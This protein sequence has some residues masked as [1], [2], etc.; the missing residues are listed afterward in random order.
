MFSFNNPFGACEK[1]DGLGVIQYFDENK[2]ISD[3]EAS[4]NSGAI[5]GWNKRNRFYYHQLKCLAAHYKFDLNCSWGSLGK[6]IQKIILYGS[7]DRIDFSKRFKAL[8]TGRPIKIFYFFINF[9][10][11]VHPY[12]PSLPF[13][14]TFRPS[15]YARPRYM[16]KDSNPN[17]LFSIQNSGFKNHSGFQGF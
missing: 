15:S 3:P 10:R 5:K 4:I 17:I 2:I 9:R 6:D 16:K 8:V 13:Q 7:Q 12:Q 1:C 14:N 11:Q